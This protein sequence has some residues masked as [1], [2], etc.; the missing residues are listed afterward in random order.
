MTVQDQPETA[1]TAQSWDTYWRGTGDAEAWTAGGASHPAIGAFW[2]RFFRALSEDLD[3]PAM[4]DIASGNGAVVERALEVFN[5]QPVEI[6]PVDVSEAAI[7]NIRARFPGVRGLV[8]DARSIPLE[9]GA[10]DIVT[11][12]FGVEYAGREAIGEATRLLA[13]GGRLALLMHHRDGAIHQ[14]CAASLDAIEQ[15]RSARF[16][17]LATDMFRAGFAAV[18]G[19][20]RQPYDAAASRLAPAVEALERMIAQHGEHVAGDTIVR[21]YGDVARIHRELPNYD[22]EEVMSWLARMGQELNAYAGRMSSMMAAAID[23]SEFERI[24]TE[25]DA[26]TVVEQAG[27]LL[28]PG[29]ELPLAWAILATGK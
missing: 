10:F 14:E 26:R 24:R 9:S 17:P 15:T 29:L 12:Q 25:L 21:L 5:Q 19:A 11:S 20:D 8:C 23:Q 27:P 1:T 7:A 6:T 13:P 18:R 28:V 22:P 3:N 16:I 4:L 2:D